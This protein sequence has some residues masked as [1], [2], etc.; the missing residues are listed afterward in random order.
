M[1]FGEANQAW[2][3]QEL[4][5]IENCVEEAVQQGLP[6][7]DGFRKAHAQLPNRTLAGI[8]NCYY[9]KCVKRDQPPKEDKAEPAM[10]VLN[11]LHEVRSQLEQI[12]KRL[13]TLESQQRFNWAEALTELANKL[14]N[15]S[16]LNR[17]PRSWGTAEPHSGTGINERT[18]GHLPGCCI[19]QVMSLQELKTKLGN[20]LHRDQEKKP[21][22]VGNW[23]T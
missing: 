5:I 3:E 17:R 4:Q 8:T 20:L 23:S 21:S 12:E 10:E 1:S 15:Y 18:E 2:S 6:K 13:N 22:R 14:R 9:T 11:L 7:A 19:Q 16:A